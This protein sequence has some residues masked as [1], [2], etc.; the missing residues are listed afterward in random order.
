MAT[1]LQESTQCQ[2]DK[3]YTC[4]PVYSENRKAVTTKVCLESQR[5]CKYIK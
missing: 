5:L 2:L 3:K 1:G 4:S